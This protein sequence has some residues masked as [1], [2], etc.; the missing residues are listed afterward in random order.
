[1]KKTVIKPK[2]KK[3]YKTTCSAAANVCETIVKV[4]VQAAIGAFFVGIG[5]SLYADRKEAKERNKK[6][7]RINNPKI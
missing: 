7:I 1:M 6:L 3:D 4:C 2:P 5:F